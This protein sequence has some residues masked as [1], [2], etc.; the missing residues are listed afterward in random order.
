MSLLIINDGSICVDL[1]EDCKKATSI[2]FFV[3]S[4]QNKET[5]WL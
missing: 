3:K 1:V 5:E 4:S 2:H